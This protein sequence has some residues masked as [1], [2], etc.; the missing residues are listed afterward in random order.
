MDIYIKVALSC[1]CTYVLDFLLQRTSLPPF[2][3]AKMIGKKNVSLSRLTGGGSLLLGQEQNG[4][5]IGHLDKNQAL[6]DVNLALN[7]CS[8][9]MYGNKQLLADYATRIKLV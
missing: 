9:E 3:N 2:V 5:M 1:S 4:E 6:M 8:K 7:K